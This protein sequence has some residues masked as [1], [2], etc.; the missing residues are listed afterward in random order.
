MTMIPPKPNDRVIAVTGENVAGEKNLQLTSHYDTFFSVLI[1]SLQQVIS[2]QGLKV[3]QLSTTQIQPLGSPNNNGLLVYNQ[4]TNQ[5][6]I[7]LN[8][9]TKTIATMP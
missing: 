8:G 1:N 2:N 7:T 5:L 3:P 4:T 6:Q 9:V